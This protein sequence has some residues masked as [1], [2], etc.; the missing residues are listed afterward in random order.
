[1]R[2]L[3][4]EQDR[5]RREA[6]VA[7]LERHGH[8]VEAV[9]DVRRGLVEA[10]GDRPGLITL[11]AHIGADDA[12]DVLDAIRS[13]PAGEA[14]IV[15]VV[16]APDEIDA[17]TA[18]ERGAG[19]V[20]LIPSEAEAPDD[21]PLRLALA[22]H[23]A[24]LQTENVRLG[25]EFAL[26]RSALDLT[27]TGFILTDPRLDDNPIV[28]A[29]RSFYDLTG[30]TEADVLGRNCRFLQGE[31]ADPRT[32]DRMRQAIAAEE[33]VTVE[34]RNQR[35]DGSSFLNE[36]HISPVR[37]ASGQ[38]VRFVGVQ[39]D[40]TQYR[41]AL[42]A[43][44][45]SAFLAAA[46]P[47]L[48][49][50]LDLRRTL[51]VLARLSVPELADVCLV[52][53]LEGGQIRRVA[54]AAAEPHF[55][56]LLRAQP[57]AY[58][59]DPAGDTPLAT[60]MRTGR[61]A[62]VRDLPDDLVPGL[63]PRAAIIVP[64]R[65]RGRAVGALVLGA[66]DA[67]RDFGDEELALAEDLGRRAAL[68]LDNARLYEQQ[69]SVADTLQASL[70]PE[71]L[72]A[73]DGLQLATRYRPAGE[74]VDIGGDFYDAF[75]VDGGALA[76]TIGDVTG[77]GALA[78]SLT[79]LTRHTLRTAAT[80]ERSPAAVLAALNRAL[81]QQRTAR[82]KYCTVAMCRLSP[83]DEGFEV[84][85]A[86][87]GHPLPLVLRRDGRVEEIG[88]PGTLLGFIDPPRIVDVHTRLEPG[89]AL[90]LYTDGLTEVPTDGGVIGTARVREALADCAGLGP[91]EIAGRLE[92]M[93]MRLQTGPPR[94]DVAVAVA[95]VDPA[96]ERAQA[97]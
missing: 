50:S 36:V 96:H 37:D 13:G 71:A 43:E 30:F 89:D 19:D 6:L 7:E 16:G 46:S 33:P 45:R 95:L 79:A 12:L 28:Y 58:A 62:F 93:T 67:G 94:D 48:D 61:A 15:V 73:V 47:R 60:A 42:R 74:G 2:A 53:V 1:M 90:V 22:E 32:V 18:L 29:N 72:P 55:E 88:R 23:Y 64:L 21:I 56:R 24:R 66:L 59:I 97:A 80:Y 35:A 76:L 44:R 87:A 3:V 20:W 85:A 49:A 70:L 57:P 82:G 10:G 31:V 69:R 8:D 68:A 40:I 34:V 5:V 52:D 75:G 4:V 86:S 78:A 17:E 9:D 91:D 63:R 11:G 39:V 81:L 27:G 38:V 51:D 84:E 54:A 77:K 26:L 92:G 25:G 65:A 41:D 14:P 83:T